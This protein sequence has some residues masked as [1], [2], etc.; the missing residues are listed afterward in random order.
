MY[1]MLVK[2]KALHTYKALSDA[3]NIFTSCVI[4]SCI[5]LFDLAMRKLNSDSAL[6]ERNTISVN[7]NISHNE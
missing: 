7:L 3:P 1:Y 2:I 4:S 5:G 6:N